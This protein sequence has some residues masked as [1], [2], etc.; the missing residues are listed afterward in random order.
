MNT[1]E[2]DQNHPKISQEMSSEQTGLDQNIR[3]TTTWDAAHR[4]YTCRDGTQI[5]VPCRISDIRDLNK[6][7]TL[8]SSGVRHVRDTQK[9]LRPRVVVSGV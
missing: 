4:R 1:N 9:R 8:P 2:N 7:K 5:E 6:K 3:K